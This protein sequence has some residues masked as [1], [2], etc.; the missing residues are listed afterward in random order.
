MTEIYNV[1]RAVTA[2]VGKHDLWFLCFTCWLIEADISVKF[3]EN[4]S[5]RFEVT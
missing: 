3:D 4:I 2:R 1:Q 5:H